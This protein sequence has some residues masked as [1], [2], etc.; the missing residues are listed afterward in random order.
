MVKQLLVLT[1]ASAGLAGVGLAAQGGESAAVRAAIDAA[2]KKFVEGAAKRDTAMIASVY[3]EDAVAYPPNGEPVKGR[4]AVQKMWQAVLDSG[5][6]SFELNTTGVESG[7][8]VAYETGTYALKTKDGKV[9]DRGKYVV[10]WKRVK[11]QWLLHR[12]I[13]NT[14]MPK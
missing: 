8:D 2:N 13:W 3:A 6:A 4:A 10:G 7:G 1:L 12:D 9:A 11:G 14:S 5:I